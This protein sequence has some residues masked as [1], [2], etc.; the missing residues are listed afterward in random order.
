MRRQLGVSLTG[1]LAVC[2]ILIV[3]GIFAMKLIPSYTEYSTIKR[4]LTEIAHNPDMADASDDEI[5]DAFTKKA[6]IDNVTAIT[7][8]DIDISRQ[9][10][11]LHVKYGV[12]IPVVSNFALHLN[13]EANAEGS[14]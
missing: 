6:S 10:L 7:A 8:A 2:A 3:I 14:R 1:F 12:D 13:F 4:D 9:P 11:K 5:R